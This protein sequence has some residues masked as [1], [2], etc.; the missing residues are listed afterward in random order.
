MESA[1]DVI[2]ARAT[3]RE[4]L[5]PMLAGSVAAHALALAVLM[6]TV[7]LADSVEAPRELMTINLNAGAPGPV[8][9]GITQ[10]GG[11][12]V[13]Q[14]APPEPARRVETPAPAPPK[15]ALPQDKPRPRQA[16]RRAPDS[17]STTPSTGAEIVEGST[18]VDTGARGTGFTGLSS[19]GGAG[20]ANVVLDTSDFCC[21]EYLQLMVET[22]KR[23]WDHRQG[24]QG[25]TIMKFTILRNG[26]L[27]AI[28]VERGS[29]SALLDRAAERALVVTTLQPLPARYTN[30]TLTVHIT[31]HY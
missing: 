21:H 20:T 3:R 1:T 5:G 24:T 31:F 28:E 16:T 17:A 30:P 7:T 15:M 9:G 23:N 29:G 8:T 25:V 12:T 18:P 26:K 2:V 10:I 4:R 13:Q 6:F 27:E 14:V 22:I 19:S 11:R